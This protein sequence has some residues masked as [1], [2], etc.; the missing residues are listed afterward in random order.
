[1]FG[2]G[3]AD[4]VQYLFNPH[5]SL[6]EFPVMRTDTDKLGKTHIYFLSDHYC[7]K[8]FFFIEGKLD[9][10]IPDREGVDCPD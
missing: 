5:S 7:I 8:H 1:M 2:A 6:I 10:K 3:H 4:D 9:E